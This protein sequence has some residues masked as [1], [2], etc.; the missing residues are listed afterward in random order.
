MTYVLQKRESDSCKYEPI[1][2]IL[3]AC[4]ALE[5][6]FHEGIPKRG[7]DKWKMT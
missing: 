3:L 4:K 6:L 7:V 5:Q 2:L 1:H